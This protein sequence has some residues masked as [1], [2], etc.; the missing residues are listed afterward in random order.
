MNNFVLSNEQI[1]I[2]EA[3][4]NPETS[5]IKVE[6]VAGAAKST[7]LYEVTKAMPTITKN[8]YLAYNTAIKDE[9]VVKFAKNTVC[10]T[11]SAFAFAEIVTKGASMPNT[12]INVI[13]KGKRILNP[14]YCWKDVL[15][16]TYKQY[17][18]KLIVID[19]MEKFFASDD[20][21]IASFFSNN[22]RP[23]YNNLIQTVVKK[24]IKAMADKK[25]ACSFGFSLKYYHILLAR[26]VIT[27]PIPYD[28]VM[29]DEFQDSQPVVLE[30]FKLIPAH[31][32][33]AVGDSYQSINGSFLH[34]TDAFGAIEKHGVTLHLT[35]SFRCSTA[36]AKR[37]E[38]YGKVNFDKTFKFK[39]IEYEKEVDESVGYLAKTNGSLI[40]KMIECDSKG[41]KYK[42][43]RNPKLIFNLLNTLIHLRPGVRIHNSS[44]KYLEEDVE[45]FYSSA[46]LQFKHNSLFS[47]ILSEHREDKILKGAI[48]LISKYSGKTI[49]STYNKALAY[50]QDKKLKPNLYMTTA[51]SS[52]GLTFGT[53]EIGEDLNVAVEE[54]L[55]KPIGERTF[56]DQETLMIGYVT[57]TRARHRLINCKYL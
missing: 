12:E 49:T 10:K 22:P 55:N 46:S 19:A 27:I 51:H 32:K 15:G 3:A 28:L 17:D 18:E 36:I 53:V 14:N 23:E 5:L 11:T 42:N 50:Y 38:K 16:L 26:G 2:I 56:D 35:K 45:A 39:G 8:L 47:F 1:A 40:A 7:T 41:L 13:K 24:N 30:I 29:I 34:T 4:L 6:A 31:T 52:K 43:I 44:L 21:T 37:V 33:I 9:A 25:L 57:A 54:V 48:A 20:L